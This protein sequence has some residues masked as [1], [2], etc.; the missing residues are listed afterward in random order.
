MD[1]IDYAYWVAMVVLS[2]VFLVGL[3][4]VVVVIYRLFTV[5]R[6][7]GHHELAALIWAFVDL[8]CAVMDICRIGLVVVGTVA[9]ARGAVRKIGSEL[10]GK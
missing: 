7:L 8:I 2:A 4:A 10:R 1:Y 9:I 5:K 3:F 6:P